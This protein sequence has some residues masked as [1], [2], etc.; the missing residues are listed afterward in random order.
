MKCGWKT[1]QGAGPLREV[2]G[3]ALRVLTERKKKNG[4]NVWYGRRKRR[5][6][7]G[8]DGRTGVPPW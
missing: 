8:T 2:E 1:G 3:R 4:K 5:R 6:E 7:Y